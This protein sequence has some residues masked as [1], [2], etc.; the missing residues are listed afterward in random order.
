M[1]HF[2]RAAGF[3][4]NWVIMMVSTTII[5]GLLLTWEKKGIRQSHVILA[6]ICFL[7]P[8]S[9][10]LA[11]L[12]PA[13]LALLGTTLSMTQYFAI[14]AFIWLSML[15]FGFVVLALF[16]HFGV[17]KGGGL[18]GLF[19]LLNFVCSPGLSPLETAYPPF[20]LGLG[21]PFLNAIEGMR[22]LLWGSY[23]HLPR[24]CGVLCAWIGLGLLVLL[25]D[26][27]VEERKVRAKPR[28]PASSDCVAAE[29]SFIKLPSQAAP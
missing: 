29:V 21:L 5:I 8:M 15:S 28:G 19:L 20:K 1:T 25:C 2:P 18:H 3:I 22:T 4:D 7:L 12:P 14:W 9:F 24:V 11:F 16:T 17:Q 10:F 13:I 23:D 26:V 27:Y 6:R